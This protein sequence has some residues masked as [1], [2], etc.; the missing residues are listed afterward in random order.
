LHT[1]RGLT[2][3]VFDSVASAYRRQVEYVR[4]TRI[5]SDHTGESLNAVVNPLPMLPN[6]SL[7]DN[8]GR[9]MRRYDFDAPARVNAD[10]Q[11]SRAATNAHRPLVATVANRE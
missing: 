2:I 8:R 5:D 10:R 1:R 7:H 11:A 9:A 3:A 6:K 4:K